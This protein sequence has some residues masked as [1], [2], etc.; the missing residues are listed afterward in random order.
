MPLVQ[1]MQDEEN[2]YILAEP[3]MGGEFFSHLC[4]DGPFVEADARF[5]AAC[6]IEALA[7]LHANGCV[8][9]SNLKGEP[10]ARETASKNG[11]NNSLWAP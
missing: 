2:L 5:Y 9:G 1:T 3:I 10:L 6:A 8:R 4:M 7:A 11:R